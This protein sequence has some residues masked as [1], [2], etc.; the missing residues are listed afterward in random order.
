[1]SIL[2]FINDEDLF[3]CIEKVVNK[4]TENSNE[5]E[6][7]DFYKNK[8]DPF[9]FYFDMKFNNIDIEEYLASEVLRK[10][11]K[12]IN[13]VIGIFHE[14]LL[15][16]IEGF[17]RIEVGGKH[18]VE[19]ADKTIFAEIKNKHNT[20]KGEDKLTIFK[21]LEN[22][23]E[24][25]PEATCYYVRIIDTKSRNEIWKFSKDKESYTHPRVRIISG[26][27][28]YSIVTGQKNAF[29]ELIEKFPAILSEYIKRKKYESKN[30]NSTNNY[31]NEL[32][33]K[34]NGDKTKLMDTIVKD[35]FES[36]LGFKKE[37]SC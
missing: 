1:M 9:K 28:F 5:M 26:D 10:N 31:L 23:A 6:L 29:K 34:S 14:E 15:G 21:K 33:E 11:D 19:S 18:D 3:S 2:N 25:F 12:S 36:Y 37:H 13:N 35:T 24:E 7:K 17:K 16:S 27:K 32:I 30:S 20:V 8:V 22:L 4:Y